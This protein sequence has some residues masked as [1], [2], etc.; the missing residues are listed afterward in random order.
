MAEGLA[1]RLLGKEADIR[2]AGSRPGARIQPEAIEVMKEIGIDLSAARPK[3]HW[4][5]PP[6]FLA[7]LDYVITLCAEEV[8]PVIPSQKAAR[9]HWPITDP[10]GVGNTAQETFAAFRKTRDRIE[11]QLR[12]F[13]LRI[14]SASRRT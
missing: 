3:F 12:P 5:L 8:C 13:A 9:L 10:V 11:E 7:G 1:R 4:D 2:S 6:E 14:L